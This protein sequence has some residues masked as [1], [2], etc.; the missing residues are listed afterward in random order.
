[1]SANG[2]ILYVKYPK[3]WATVTGRPI[4]PALKKQT[5]PS[6]RPA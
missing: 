5:I 6:S 3:D 2:M 4:M 1:L